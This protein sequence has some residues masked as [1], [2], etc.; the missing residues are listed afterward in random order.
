MWPHF[1]LPWSRVCM[2][3]GHGCR[4]SSACSNGRR[5]RGGPPCSST[6]IVFHLSLWLPPPVMVTLLCVYMVTGQNAPFVCNLV[7]YVIAAYSSFHNIENS[8]KND[9][10]RWIVFWVIFGLFG[11]MDHFNDQIREHFPLFW[12]F[13]LLFLTWCLAPTNTNG[14]T[15]IY[16]HLL[17]PLF[18]GVN[19]PCTTVP[20][21]GD[22][23]E[24]CNRIWQRCYPW[25][26]PASDEEQRRD[27][28]KST[29][30]PSE[31]PPADKKPA[32]DSKAKM[33][34]STSTIPLGQAGTEKQNKEKMLPKKGQA[35]ASDSKG[36]GKVTADATLEKNK[37]QGAV[38]SPSIAQS[39]SSPEK[40][41]KPGAISSLSKAQSSSSP[42]KDRKQGVTSPP[43]KAQSPPSP[44]KD[45]KP[46]AISSLSKAQSSSSPEKDRK[47][48]VTSPPSKAQS[49]SSPEKDKKP[50]VTSTPSK[51]QSS[52][53]VTSKKAATPV[54][55]PLPSTS[56]DELQPSETT[57]QAVPVLNEPSSHA[58]IKSASDSVIKSKTGTQD[59][60]EETYESHLSSKRGSQGVKSERGAGASS[61]NDI[62]VFSKRDEDVGRR[63]LHD[64]ERRGSVSSFLANKSSSIPIIQPVVQPL[65]SLHSS[66]YS[67]TYGSANNA[68]FPG[69]PPAG[70]YAFGPSYPSYH[71]GPFYP[72]HP[73][74]Y[75]RARMLFYNGPMQKQ[76]SLGIKKLLSPD[77]SEGDSFIDDPRPAGKAKAGDHAGGKPG[78]HKDAKSSSSK[79]E[80]K[81]ATGEDKAEDK[82]KPA[83]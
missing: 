60:N 72:R 53:S 9:D 58:P 8:T 45:K 57:V 51:A 46:G 4:A 62:S 81:K 65:F 14:V 73:L 48:G 10:S 31:E 70:P 47:Q 71:A 66:P 83:G 68:P 1:W 63:P 74:G 42:E 22:G 41:K 78:Q 43:I 61:W 26:P 20:N 11:M 17:Y 80:G 79:E 39:T 32:G 44:E 77:E 69:Q 24:L 33:S 15:T 52:A 54:S 49:P 37:N 23:Q 76:K 12:L 13:K 36:K 34:T 56:K 50:G 64:E 67:S 35:A 55:K 30:P 21:F 2:R 82:K 29:G 3:W 16:F 19:D 38:S 7:I 5:G 75:N 6:N 18:L 28:G 59:G 27:A 25:A 40:D